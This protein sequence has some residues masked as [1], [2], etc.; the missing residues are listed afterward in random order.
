MTLPGSF[1]RSGGMIVGG[2]SHPTAMAFSRS[3]STSLARMSGRLLLRDG[4]PCSPS[5][6]A[7]GIPLAAHYGYADE[8]GSLPAERGRRF[9]HGRSFDFYAANLQRKYGPNYLALWREMVLKRLRAWGFNTIGNWSEPGLLARRE[10]A[11]VVPIHTY[12]NFA[13]VSGG[14]DK[15]PDPFDPSCPA[16]RR[17]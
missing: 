12:G 5:F 17:Y 4:N 3:A 1:A 9:G 15:V 11:Y 13:R 16:R 10:L 6:P 14:W 7:R 2:S 8:R